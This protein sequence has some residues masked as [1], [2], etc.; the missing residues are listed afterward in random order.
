M[1][2]A[3][4]CSKSHEAMLA[5]YNINKTFAS[6]V[7]LKRKKKTKQARNEEYLKKNGLG[8]GPMCNIHEK[9]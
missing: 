3:L 4:R 6:I 7:T 2:A 9:Q 5:H 8:N 1:C